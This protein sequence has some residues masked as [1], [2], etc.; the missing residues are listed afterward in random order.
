MIVFIASFALL[1]ARR[2]PAAMDALL[3]TADELI[4]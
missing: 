3:V 2:P 1:Q 4:E